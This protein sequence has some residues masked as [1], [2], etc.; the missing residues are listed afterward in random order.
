RYQ[1]GAKLATSKITYTD[2]ISADDLQKLQ[3][4]QKIARNPNF[5]IDRVQQT[6]YDL[7]GNTIYDIDPAG[8]VRWFNRDVAGRVKEKVLYEK[9]IQAQRTLD[10]NLI[11][12]M[13][14]NDAAGY[15]TY[16]FRD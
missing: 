1:P 11:Q 3:Q 6:I 14:N 13:P 16:Y 12:V 2:P 8:Y 4:K 7:D 5:T 10:D 15:H 9:S